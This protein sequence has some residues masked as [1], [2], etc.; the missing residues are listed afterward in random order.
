MICKNENITR[1]CFARKFDFERASITDVNVC[2]RHL[3]SIDDFYKL[4]FFP[5][6]T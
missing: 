2:L 5:V 1:T 6:Y 4:D 3:F